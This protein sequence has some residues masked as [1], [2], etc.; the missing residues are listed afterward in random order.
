MEKTLAIIKP[1]S[2]EKKVVGKIIECIEEHGFRICAMKL[3]RMRPEQAGGFYAEHQGKPFFDGLVEYMTSGA[4]VVAVLQAEGAIGKWRE[5]MGATDP[6]SAAEGTLR[7]RFGTAV[8]RNATHG[9]DSPQSAAREVAYF[10]TEE[11]LCD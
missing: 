10:F 1:D 4:S 2:V 6:A 9:S 8:N 7:K 11:E 3:L 5:L